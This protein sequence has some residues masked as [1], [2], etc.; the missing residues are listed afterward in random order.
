MMVRERLRKLFASRAFYIVFSILASVT[1]WLY[2]AYIENPDVAVN[3]KGIK[4]EFLKEDY[5]TDRG[6]VITSIDTDSLTLRFNGRRNTVTKLSATNVS[7][8]VDLSDIKTTGVFQLTYDIEYPIDINTSAISISSRSVDF[9]TVNVDYLENKDIP[10]KGTYDGG[11]AEGYQAEP[12][13]LTPSTITVS[14]PREVLSK[15]SYAWVYVNRENISKTVEESLPFKLMDDSGNQIT[16]EKLHFS[17]D[18]INVKIPVV[19]IKE[20]PLTVTLLTGAGADESNT[21]LTISPEQITVS[22]DAQTLAGLN[23]IVLGTVDLTKFVSSTSMKFQ[24]VLPND[25]KNLTGTSEAEV[26]V[27]VS[28]L[29][30]S[31]IRTTNIDLINVTEGYTASVVTKDLEVVLRG[32][33]AELQKVKPSNIRIV[34]DLVELGAATGTVSVVAK[35]SIDG[36]FKTVG[37][38]GEYKITVKLTKG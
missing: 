27:T 1:I 13:E 12:I 10:V 22:G 21:V 16:S 20:I 35:I 6:L 14:G 32:S 23:Q 15:I 2:V 3:V 19:M 34:A 18:A 25:T 37:V 31:T 4:V 17:Q 29:E 30:T 11:V 36:D 24:I 7:A 8:T 5:V 28:G 33:G 9:V 38:I 26:T